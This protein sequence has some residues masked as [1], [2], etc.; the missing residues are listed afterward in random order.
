MGQMPSHRVS[1]GFFHDTVVCV[2]A[3]VCV[4]CGVCVGAN[5]QNKPAEP[6]HLAPAVHVL[7][8]GMV[9]SVYGGVLNLFSMSVGHLH[10]LYTF[11]HHS[12]VMKPEAELCVGLVQ[13]VWTGST[14]DNYVQLVLLLL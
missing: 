14:A 13:C 3:R 6:E 9:V 5:P 1:G 2:R 12:R 4:E 7:N 8:V 10:T 11:T